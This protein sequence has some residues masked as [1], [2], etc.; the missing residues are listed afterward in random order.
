VSHLYDAAGRE[1]VRKYL[2]LSGAGLAIYT[3]T[4][5]AVDN[6]LTVLEIDGSQYTYSYDPTNQLVNE[7]RTGTF[8]YNATYTYDHVGNRLVKNDSSALTTYSY[9]AANAL[10]LAVNPT[11]QPTT[12]SYDANG[13]LLLDNAGGLLTTYTWDPQNRLTAVSFNDGTSETNAYDATGHRQSNNIPGTGITYF[14]W[15]GQ[16]V[17]IRSNP[18]SSPLF[19]GLAQRPRQVSMPARPSPSSPAAIETEP[20]SR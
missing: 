1:T 8:A 5:D 15:D 12:S 4:Y 18:T 17:L 14:V 20:E 11:G 16:N 13:N 10:L 3:A 2:A 6:R 7:F 19:T 9:N